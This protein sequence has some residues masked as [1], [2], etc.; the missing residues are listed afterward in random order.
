MYF[1]AALRTTCIRKLFDRQRVTDWENIKVCACYGM[2][3][4]S[5]NM[6]NKHSISV[7]YVGGL[8][9]MYRYSSLKFSKLYLS[10]YIPGTSRFH[11]LQ[12]TQAYMDMNTAIKNCVCLINSNG[13]F[14]VAG[15]YKR[16]IIND[17]ILIAAR[18]SNKT[19]NH[20]NNTEEDFQVDA[21]DI[22]Y[23]FVQTIPT[24]R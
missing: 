20:H 8:R 15:W 14:T 24:N 10:D 22:C 11:R 9:N 23:H 4:N 19:R 12:F 18:N 7:S 1:S 6:V 16:G 21:G 2:L 17:I 3:S 13:G 5:S